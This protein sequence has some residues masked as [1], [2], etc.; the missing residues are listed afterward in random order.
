MDEVEFAQYTSGLDADQQDAVTQV[1]GMMLTLA[2]DLVESVNDGRWLNGLI[3]YS[4]CGSMLFAVGPKGAKK[5][6]FHMMPFYGSAALQSAHREA[7]APF[8]TG[9]SCITFRR[10]DDLPVHNIADIIER[11]T[12]G[13]IEAISS[14][15]RP[16]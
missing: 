9:K 15:G 3:F 6:V 2:P 8:L 10:F 5:T 11:G 7:L 12:P 13:M 16:G 14:P 1:R 4:A